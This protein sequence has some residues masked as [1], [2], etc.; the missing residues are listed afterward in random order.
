M[1]FHG[2]YFCLIFIVWHG[3]LRHFGLL[4]SN[5]SPGGVFIQFDVED[6][7]LPL[8]I[9]LNVAL[10]LGVFLL[11][12]VSHRFQG[13]EAYPQI[14]RNLESKPRIRTGQVVR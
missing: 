7:I 12:A 5:L 8:I 9:K 1:K 2:V 13:T 11:Q 10:E 3:V 4:R 6:K 14:V